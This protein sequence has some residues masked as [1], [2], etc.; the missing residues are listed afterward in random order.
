MNSHVTPG[1]R[2]MLGALPD[3]VRGQGRSAYRQF[4][5]NPR[6]PSL[7]FKQIHGS[8]RL[9]SVRIGRGYRAV[10]VRRSPDEIVW[11][12]VGAHGEYEK[13]LAK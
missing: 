1:F 12:W 6:H 8:D 13:L 4:K 11:F 7:R 10:G 5:V 2:E 3:E 9:V